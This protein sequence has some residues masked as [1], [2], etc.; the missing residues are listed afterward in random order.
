MRSIFI[1]K[2][3]EYAERDPSVYLLTGDL[4]FS[5]HEPFKAAFPNRFIN[6][7]IAEQNMIGMAAGLA[8][9]GK[10][11]FIYSIIPFL[12]MRCFEQIRNN[13]CYQ[14][15]NV[16]LW[17]VGGGLSYGSAGLTH[18]A[19]EDIAIMNV[20]PNMTI[21]APGSKYEASELIP[22]FIETDG[23]GYL[24]IA[25]TDELVQYP[26]NSTPQLGKILEIIPHDE[27]LILATSNA[28]DLAYQ[29]QQNLTTQDIPCGLASVHTVKPFDTAYLLNKQHTLKAV[30][31]IEEHSVI[32]GLGSIVASTIM[33]NFNHHVS[34]K[35]FGINDFYFHEAGSRKDLLAKAELTV[36][37][38]VNKVREVQ[39]GCRGERPASCHKDGSRLQGF[40]KATPD[41]V[42]VRDDKYGRDTA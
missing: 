8:M 10:K 42:G 17:G 4:G 5:V 36:E 12:T 1:K 11:V 39:G 27:T 15:F 37:P 16:K 9:A 20:L 13:L 26:T 35:I 38:I 41:A 28:L 23:P 3:I 31:T 6:A 32:G 30:F 34:C 14:N 25:N 19:I 33:Q 21:L 24:R 18:H 22:A 2:L 40:A 7:G 29:V